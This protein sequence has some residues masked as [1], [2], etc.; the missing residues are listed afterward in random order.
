MRDLLKVLSAFKEAMG[1]ALFYLLLISQ[2]LYSD[3]VVAFE[4]S[5]YF[6]PDKGANSTSKSSNKSSLMTLLLVNETSDPINNIELEIRGVRKIN[7]IGA[8]SSSIR[9][10]K[11]REE[12]V[13]FEERDNDSIF[14]KNI[15]HIPPG[16][17]IQLQI[18]AEFLT[19]IFDERIKITSSAKSK[20]VTE[21]T[22]VSGFWVFLYHQSTLIFTIIAIPLIF[23]G[24]KRYFKEESDQ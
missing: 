18:A 2:P 12:L 8:R 7:S 19:L 10:E 24:I 11:A 15:K 6:L 16:H 20:S 9:L 23:I 14:L 13:K 17:N 4:V 3:L 5:D 21:Y 22:K 1:V